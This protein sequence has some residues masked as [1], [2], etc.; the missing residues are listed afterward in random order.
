MPNLAAVNR[1]LFHPLYLDLFWQFIAE[2]QLVWW[3]RSVLKQEGP[4]TKDVVMQ[5]EFITNVYRELD[6]GTIYVLR[7]ILETSNHPADKIFNVMMFRLMGSQIETH[8]ALGF[9]EYKKFKPATFTKKLQTL[10]AAGTKVFGDSYRVA[11][12]QDEGG[13]S[14]IE[15][16]GLL[17]GRLAV[18]FEETYKSLKATT[19][20][21]SLWDGIKAVRGLGDFLAFQIMCDLLY[22][23]E[24][25]N[26]QPMFPY[27]HNDWA[28]P[29]PGAK[30]GMMQ[31]VRPGLVPSSYLDAMEWLRDNM[32][33][34]LKRLD[35]PFMYLANSDGSAKYLHTADIQSCLCE[36]FKYSR[37]WSS[38][39]RAVR[40]FKPMTASSSLDEF[41]VVLETPSGDVES[42]REILAG[43]GRT[44]TPPV[45]SAAEHERLVRLA[46][47]GSEQ[48]DGG[49]G[50]L[51]PGD[52]VV[53]QLVPDYA[54]Q[55]AQAGLVGAFG[56]GISL[57]DNQPRLVMV[58]PLHQ[59]GDDVPYALMIIPIAKA[60]S[61]IAM[62]Q[63]TNVVD[64]PPAPEPD[65][66]STGEA[67]VEPENNES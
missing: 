51:G 12:Y 1:E 49:A 63:H 38:Q 23:I 43:N 47:S 41:P 5:N 4:W 8:Q 30:N 31:L 16:V 34:E 7:N 2:R 36:F 54:A 42:V 46:I 18:D 22:P 59:L 67:E 14:K 50:G 20:A 52:A 19:S 40:K 62:I 10:D 27:T 37:I 33:E 53:G 66:A 45:P 61:G 55:L 60:R 28:I 32:H 65:S 26:G 64:V 24:M 57:N 39:S 29:G 56:Q 9:Q 35:L 48:L 15:N 3:R 25:M 6:P 11:P 44:L 58:D 17:F 21:R 13:S